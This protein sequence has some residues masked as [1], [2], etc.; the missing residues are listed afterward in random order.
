MSDKVM[1]NFGGDFQIEIDEKQR[2]QLANYLKNLSGNEN[3]SSYDLACLLQNLDRDKDLP[4]EIFD[5][6]VAEYKREIEKGNDDAMLNLGALYYHG[7]G[8]EQDFT[9]AFYYYKMAS[10]CGNQQAQEN[11]GYCYYY[12]RSVRVDYEKAF[13]YFAL[14]AF[15]GRA[16]SL[17][18]IGD[19]YKNGYYVE[20]NLKEAFRLYQRAYYESD[21]ENENIGPVCLRLGDAYL[22]GE[23]VEPD[24]RKAL[25]YFQKAEIYLY[26][27][28]KNGDYMY[29]KSLKAAVDNQDIAR[30]RLS[31]ILDVREWAFE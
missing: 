20:K 21:E 29:F 16:V 5:L 1:L 7:H 15:E 12:G 30:I 2:P 28:I 11:L 13:H 27:A 23:G 25:E 4:R 31:A 9:K 22:K 10:Q 6:I 24:Y 3:L 18:K 8:C 14:G 26:D 19:M 17:Y